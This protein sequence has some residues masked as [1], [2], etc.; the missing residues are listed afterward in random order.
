MDRKTLFG[1]FVISVLVVAA[2]FL[3]HTPTPVVVHV[4]YPLQAPT[5]PAN[6]AGTQTIVDEYINGLKVGDRS[7]RWVA[8]SIP[9]GVNQVGYVN[10]TGHG[11][12]VDGVE[13]LTDGVASSTF[14]VFAATSTTG[15]V[16]TAYDFTRPF[17]SLID[18][19][20]IATSTPAY[21]LIT[22]EGATSTVNQRAVYVPDGQ[23]VV[24]GFIQT[25]GNPCTGSVCEAAT[26]TNRGFNAT[27]KLRVQ[28]TLG[29]F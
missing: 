24:I 19:E 7:S 1:A 23:G 18:G 26:S 21:K 28:S 9:A 5:A 15:V 6:L 14:K 16:S 4:D 25:Y 22:S 10:R 3:L 27:V 8:L 12:I 20:I 29:F 2:A 17:S 11:V 13:F